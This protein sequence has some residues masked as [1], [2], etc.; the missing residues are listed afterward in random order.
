MYGTAVLGIMGT[1]GL[2]YWLGWSRPTQL[3]AVTATPIQ[4]LTTTPSI[5]RTS[6]S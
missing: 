6:L 3:A 5:A 2:L 4:T 1:V